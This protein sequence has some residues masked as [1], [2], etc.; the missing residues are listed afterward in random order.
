MILL[1]FEADLSSLP[2]ATG[3]MPPKRE[4][5]LGRILR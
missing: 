2:G 5:I 4:K 1:G 3:E